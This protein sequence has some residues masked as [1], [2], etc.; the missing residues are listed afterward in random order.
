[1]ES[2]AANYYSPIAIDIETTVEH[3]LVG[4]WVQT[5][6]LFCFVKSSVFPTTVLM[7]TM[8]VRYLLVSKGPQLQ[9]FETSDVGKL[10]LLHKL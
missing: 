2:Q 9:T 8:V 4:L 3:Y 5:D 1:M 6:L 7:Q 10:R